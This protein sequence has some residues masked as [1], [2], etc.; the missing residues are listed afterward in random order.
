M[1]LCSNPV[2]VFKEVYHNVIFLSFFSRTRRRLQCSNPFLVFKEVYHNAIFLS[3]FSRTKR[4]LQ[5]CRTSLINF[6]HSF[7]VL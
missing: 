5:Q 4:H 3:F 6:S 2:F 7:L 1:T